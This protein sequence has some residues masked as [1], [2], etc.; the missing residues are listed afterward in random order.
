MEARRDFGFNY[1]D[2]TPKIDQTLK[3][4]QIKDFAVLIS[5]VSI[6]SSH[7]FPLIYNPTSTAPYRIQAELSAEWIP[8]CHAKFVNIVPNSLSFLR[9]VNLNDVCWT[10][11]TGHGDYCKNFLL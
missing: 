5:I 11:V 9:E 6:Q 4:G 2:M 1:S 3:N 10:T 7:N 8:S